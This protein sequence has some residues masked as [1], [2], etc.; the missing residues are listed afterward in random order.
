MI[1]SGQIKFLS[2][3]CNIYRNKL[4]VQ[5]NFTLISHL[6]IC[7]CTFY[8]FL[9][10]ALLIC[11][12]STRYAET[13][14]RI[15]GA[16]WHTNITRAILF[17]WDSCNDIIKLRIGKTTVHCIACEFSFGSSKKLF[18]FNRVYTPVLL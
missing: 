17:R 8:L 5:Y 16:R 11:W 12:I 9:P 7:A 14:V 6:H 15:Y 18:L 1:L 10:N 2:Y 4:I 3:I 13:H